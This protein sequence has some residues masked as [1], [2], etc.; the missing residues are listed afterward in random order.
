MLT[1]Y[2]L[3]AVPRSP[4]MQLC[5]VLL[6]YAYYRCVLHLESWYMPAIDMPAEPSSPAAADPLLFV[7]RAIRWLIAPARR[8]LFY[9]C[10][11]VIPKFTLRLLCNVLP[12]YVHI[13]L[14]FRP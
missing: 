6:L 12:R 5:M 10:F 11:F 9:M 1:T 14:T 3:L 7:L 8:A 13:D 2:S 4:T